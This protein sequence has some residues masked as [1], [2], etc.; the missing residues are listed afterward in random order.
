[1]SIKTATND[2]PI[3]DLLRKR[4][5]PRAFN[6][7]PVEKEKLQSLF[8][9]ARWSASSSNQQP[10]FF[11]IGHKGDDTYKKIQSTL[12]EFNQLWAPTAPVLLLAIAKTTNH[13]GAPNISAHY[14]L[15]QSVA[16]LSLQATA[17]RLFIHQM[18]GFDADEAKKL[19]Q[20]PSDYAV[21]TAIA[22]GYIGDPE[23][24][25]ENLK[26]SEVLPRE[27][28]KAADSVFSDKFGQSSDIF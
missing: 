22:I 18:G 10:W 27:R 12:V 9:A 20:I 11:I 26:K 25:H 4:W 17:E 16:Y 8:E 13:K 5:S 24:L 2:Y 15:G 14:D 3:I 7:Q 6:G 23:M 21:A 19:F 28:R 1:M